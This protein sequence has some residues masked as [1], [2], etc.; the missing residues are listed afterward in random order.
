MHRFFI[1]RDWIDGNTV[2][3]T[4]KQAR[5]LKEVLRFA[6]GDRI[7][8]LDNS[9]RELEY[10]VDI[11]DITSSKVVGTIS[12]WQSTSREP[13]I[14][15]TLY[16]ALLKGSKFDQVVQKCTEIGASAFVPVLCE[17]CI[18]RAPGESRA[19]RWQAIITEASEQSGRS[20]VPALYPLVSF[21]QACNQAEGF[22][23]L[24]WENEAV[25]GI[26]AAMTSAEEVSSMSIFIG[27]EGGFSA[28]EVEMARSKGI[29]PVTLGKRLLRAET[30]GLVALTAVLYQR[31]EIG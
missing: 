19:V 5:Q 16:Q 27:P 8:V 28:C 18:A 21:E 11:L 1:P 6:A 3:I 10:L 13:E 22:S 17:R 31:N 24:P 26:K 25:F 30:A 20:R 29:I 4:G 15:I 9:E 2:I 23:L 14:K 12:G 7:V